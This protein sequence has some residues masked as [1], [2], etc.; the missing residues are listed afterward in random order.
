MIAAFA[1]AA[2][3]A[4]QADAARLLRRR[5]CRHHGV[6]DS[7]DNSGVDIDDSDTGFKIYGGYSFNDNF[8]VEL[9]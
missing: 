5:E 6:S 1:L 9:S 4:A 8:A 2:S 3:M 7:F